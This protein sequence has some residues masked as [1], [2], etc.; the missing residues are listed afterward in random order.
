MEN[1]NHCMF[2][3]K[4][5]STVDIEEEDKA[6]IKHR[7]NALHRTLGDEAGK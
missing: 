7:R 4:P 1:K 2:K 5:S 3:S 6:K